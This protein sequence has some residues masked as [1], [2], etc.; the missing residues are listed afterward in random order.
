MWGTLKTEEYLRRYKRYDKKNNRELKA[1]LNNLDRFLNVLNSGK[2]PK[3]PVYAFLHPE[4]SDVMAVTQ[5]GNVNLMETRLYVYPDMEMETLYL[6]TIGNKKT[7]HDDIQLCKG[8]VEQIR[9]G[10]VSQEAGDDGDSNGN[11][12]EE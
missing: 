6:L 3:P 9:E 1:V 2:N 10:S 5:G 4:P 11:D 8:Y 7:Q 12:E